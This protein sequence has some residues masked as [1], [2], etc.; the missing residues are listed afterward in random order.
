MVWIPMKQR[1]VKTRLNKIDLKRGEYK[2]VTGDAAFM[3]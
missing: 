1:K 3:I 2:D